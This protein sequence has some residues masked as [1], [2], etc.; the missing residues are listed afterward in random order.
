MGKASFEETMDNFLNAAAQGDVE[1][2]DGVSASIICGKRAKIGTGMMQIGID[3][4]NLPLPTEEV[5]QSIALSMS[6]LALTEDGEMP[7]FTDL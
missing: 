3:M 6:H 5:E 7:M 4:S 1:S 2:T